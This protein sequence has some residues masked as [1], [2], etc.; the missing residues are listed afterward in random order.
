MFYC[1]AAHLSHS[2][3]VVYSYRVY[4][5]EF[6]QQSPHRKQVGRV[7]G[8]SADTVSRADQELMRLGLLDCNLRAQ[9]PADGQFRHKRDQDPARHWRHSLLSWTLFVR[10][11]SCGLSPLSMA[12]WSYVVHCAET[13]WHPRGGFGASY[14]ATI[15]RANRTA[16]QRVL[17]QL[18]QSGLI[19]RRDG[20]WC[21]VTC[22]D[23]SWLADKWDNKTSTTNRPSWQA[24]PKDREQII[25]A[26]SYAGQQQYP[27]PTTVIPARTTSANF[28]F[29]YN[30]T[31]GLLDCGRRSHPCQHG[32]TPRH[33]FA[34]CLRSP[35][36]LP[37]NL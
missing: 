32:T 23:W 27:A 1:D 35:Q 22:K 2:E 17:G 9:K 18:E 21:P 8:L 36:P 5:D 26:P 28:A 19:M 13:R 3:L 15:V 14:L 10:S 4:Q 16:I 30:G 31:S 20:C 24:L 12:V 6:S 37:D 11:S 25:P 33:G 29:G 34:R 7:V